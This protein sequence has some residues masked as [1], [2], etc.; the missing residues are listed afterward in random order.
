MFIIK[1]EHGFRYS[2][3][4]GSDHLGDVTGNIYIFL[5]YI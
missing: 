1:N 4:K 2:M 5:Y 3:Y